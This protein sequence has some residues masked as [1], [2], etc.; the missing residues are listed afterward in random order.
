MIVC[1]GVRT[2]PPE[3][4]NDGSGH[5]WLQSLPSDAL[6]HPAIYAF[7]HGL[8]G[9]EGSPWTELLDQGSVLVESIISLQ[10]DEKVIQPCTI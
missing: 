8:S 2:R 6:P 5:S 1:P 4:W 7:E 9:D 10:E 3:A